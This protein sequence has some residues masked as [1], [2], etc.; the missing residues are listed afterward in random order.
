MLWYFLVFD[1]LVWEIIWGLGWLGWH[2]ECLVLVL[3]ELGI[4]ID[5]YGG[6]ADFIFLYYECEWV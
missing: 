3:R 6:G 5:L 1:E 4:M 2:I